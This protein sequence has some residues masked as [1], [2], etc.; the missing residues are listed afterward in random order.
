M[1]PLQIALEQGLSDGGNLFETL[2]E[3]QQYEIE[4]LDDAE[5]LVEALEKF[6]QRPIEAEGVFSPFHA[7]ISLFQ[8]VTAISPFQ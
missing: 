2:N 3:L 1:T 5:S 4:S 6:L 7:L 8:S